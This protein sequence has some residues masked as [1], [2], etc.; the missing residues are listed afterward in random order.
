MRPPRPTR[1]S[2]CLYA[3]LWGTLAA[4]PLSVHAQVV[5]SQLYGG[6]GATTGAG[7]DAVGPPRL[8]QPTSANGDRAMARATS[9]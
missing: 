5:I 6:G 7:S 4:S 2:T 1:L 8:A 9:M 3:A